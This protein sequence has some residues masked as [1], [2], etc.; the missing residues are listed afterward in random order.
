LK[1]VHLVAPARFGGLERVVRELAINQKM[2]GDKVALIAL[3][4]TGVPEPSLL[5][6]LRKKEIRVIS[7]AH[8][9]RSF[10]AQRSSILQICRLVRPDVIHSHGYLPD[11]LSASLGQYF[12]AARVSTAHGFTGGSLRNRFYE[13]LQRR[14][15]LRIDAVVAVSRQLATDL[16]SSSQINLKLQI[17]SNAWEPEGLLLNRSVA[18]HVLGLPENIFTVGWVGRISREKGPDVL[19][20][21]LPRL[22]DLSLHLVFIGDGGEL[23]KL[24]RRAK[25]LGVANRVL[26]KGEVPEASKLF[27]AF[28]V[29]VNSSRTEGTPITL[30]EAM[31]AGVPIIATAVGGVPDVVSSDEALVIPPENPSALAAA[32]R[33]VHNAQAQAAAR[34][35]HAR[36]RLQREFAVSPWIASYRRVYETAATIR[37]SR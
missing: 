33:T 36:L 25:S 29:F 11:V 18:R 3:L 15:Y 19:L 37:N 23:P 14:S 24:Q 12:S 17:I 10:R 1:I 21:A 30:F 6:D 4:E 27:S 9:A 5:N 16:G 2:A 26:W 35:E 34:A 28:D 7:V 8:S 31:G 13:W 32:I 20:E 22:D